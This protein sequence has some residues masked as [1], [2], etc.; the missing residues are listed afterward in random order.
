LSRYNAIVHCPFW[1]YTGRHFRCRI[2][3]INRRIAPQNGRAADFLQGRLQGGL[4]NRRRKPS[5]V[6]D[7]SDNTITFS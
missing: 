5:A 7:Q 1:Q 6:T 3:P 2:K 4:R